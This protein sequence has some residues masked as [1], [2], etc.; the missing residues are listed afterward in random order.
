MGSAHRSAHRS[1][2]S[3][4]EAR[5]CSSRKKPDS[6]LKFRFERVWGADQALGQGTYADTGPVP[7]EEF[8]Q[9]SA[10]RVRFEFPRALQELGVGQHTGHHRTDD[11]ELDC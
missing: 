3:P 10:Y 5:E 2:L 7:I 4:Y 11:V 8:E 6:C 9:H 1:R